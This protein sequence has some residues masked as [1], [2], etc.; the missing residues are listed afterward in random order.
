MSTAVCRPLA[1]P[2]PAV[3]QVDEMLRDRSRAEA[4]LGHVDKL[5]LMLSMLFRMA[6]S[7]HLTNPD[8]S[9]EDVVRLCRCLL[10]TLCEV[11][12]KMF[13]CFAHSD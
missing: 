12:V 10:G 4:L 5:L 6:H 8:V 9:E 11:F 13:Q 3:N 7:T 2:V 1:G